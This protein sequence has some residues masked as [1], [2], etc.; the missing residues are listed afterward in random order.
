M[1]LAECPP[2]KM[3]MYTEQEVLKWIDAELDNEA[4]NEMLVLGDAE[5][6]GCIK[7]HDNLIQKKKKVPP[8]QRISHQ[9]QRKGNHPN[10]K[11][12][13]LFGIYLFY[14]SMWRDIADLTDEYHTLRLEILW[15]Y[16]VLW[17]SFFLCSGKAPI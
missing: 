11:V 4:H 1:L 15:Y 5:V 9:N 12:F 3:H 14:K 10:L 17:M 2:I 13:S 16:T 6:E 8:P 7:E